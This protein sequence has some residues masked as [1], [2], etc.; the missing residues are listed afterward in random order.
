MNT[1]NRVKGLLRH[2]PLAGQHG[3]L[4]VYRH[5][6]V[7]VALGYQM[8]LMYP[9]FYRAQMLLNFVVHEK[10]MN[11][12][13]ARQKMGRIGLPS[14]IGSL[15]TYLASDESRFTTGNSHIIDGGWSLG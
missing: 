4:P 2:L 10:A 3:L 13:V 12:F 5:T 6:L 1:I 15:A 11:D 7:W 8:L 9:A 14:E